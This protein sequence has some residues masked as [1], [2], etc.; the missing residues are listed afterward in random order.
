MRSSTVI[1]VFLLALYVSPEAQDRNSLAGQ[2]RGFGA[3]YAFLELFKMRP[4]AL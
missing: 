2:Q 1:L 3:G 4:P